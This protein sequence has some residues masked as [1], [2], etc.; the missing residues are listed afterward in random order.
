MRVRKHE[1]RAR[2]VSENTWDRDAVNE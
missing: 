1:L 2:G